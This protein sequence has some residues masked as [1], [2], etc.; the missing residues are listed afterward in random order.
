MTFRDKSLEQFTI[1]D[2]MDAQKN[3]S[4]AAFRR[5]K[6]VA[7]VASLPVPLLFT[8]R[9]RQP[10]VVFETTYG[11]AGLQQRLCD[12]PAVKKF[13]EDVKRWSEGVVAAL[14]LSAAQHTGISGVSLPVADRLAPNLKYYVKKDSYYHKEPSRIGFIFPRHGVYLHY[15]A[16]RGHGGFVG[17]HWLDRFGRRHDTD[18]AS[19]GLAGKGE[20]QAQDWFNSVLKQKLPELADIAANYC[21]DMFVNFSKLYI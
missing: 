12:A 20:R 6:R 18:P 10:K 13:T 14:R 2:W 8:G 15:G 17:S 5:L 7:T 4:T 9:V 1:Q 19:L 16:Y 3:M 11:E 21:G